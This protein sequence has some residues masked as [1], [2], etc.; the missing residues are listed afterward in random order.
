MNV[1][2]GCVKMH[3]EGN[4]V[5]SYK[6]RSEWQRDNSMVLH[7]VSISNFKMFE[8]IKLVFE[9]GFNLILG[10]NGVG[11][12]T[13]LEA[14][15]VALS[16]FFVGMEDVSAR[17]IYKDDVHYQI[18][19]DN[20]GTP[21]KSYSSPTEIGS[22]LEYDR[23]T[24]PWIRA[25][26]DATGGS[27]T[28][29]APREIIQISQ[30]L[31]NGSNDK[32]W[33]LIS[34]QSASRH[35]ISARSDANEKKRK[36]LHD[37][38]CGYLGCLDKTIH[39]QSIY[40]WCKQ[41]EWLSV[42]KHRAPE[43]YEIFSNIISKFM[44]IIN[45]GMVSAVFFHPNVEKLLYV[46]NGEFREIEDLS[47]G[48]QSVLNLVIDLAYRMA[49]LNPDAG[50]NIQKAEG[51]VLIDEIDSNLHP[52]W[53]WRI[54]DAL[55]ETF[56][57]IQFIVASHS[58]IIVSSCKKANIINVEAEQTVNYVESSYAFSVNEILRDMLGYHM[59]PEKVEKLIETFEDYMAQDKYIKAKEV[60]VQ[61]VDILGSDHP[62]TIALTSELSMEAE[63]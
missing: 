23:K 55:T 1:Q 19:Q 35:W 2:I 10:D 9:P 59:R 40:D 36:Q 43:N 24:Y 41:M 39:L 57:N 26:K 25:K 6:N 12:T 50:S 46:E 37:R 54:V 62:E 51:I 53:Q 4:T 58:P 5:C 56:P 48:Y 20:N 27:K 8:H 34:Y 45:D 15:A 11:K 47:A 32:M 21:N 61:L 16:G 31:T 44:S 28:T 49:I 22:K 7:E 42:K 52:K 30:K 3:V 63:D 13:I 29:I 38:R 17:N 14:A 60:L 33:P 18:I